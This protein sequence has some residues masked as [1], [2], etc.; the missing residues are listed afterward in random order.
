MTDL[1]FSF[2]PVDPLRDAEL[3][4]SWIT[5]PK[6]A[7]WMMQ[8]ARLEDIER[9][10]ME[11]AADEHQQALLGLRDGV[12]AF[13][14]ERYDPVHRELVGLYEPRPGDVGMHF[15]TPATD[16]PEHGFTK[17]VITAV[18][19]HLFEDPAV[20]RVVVEPDV[21]NKA[22]HALNAAVG[23]VAEREIQKPEKEALL[24]FCTREQF[25]KAV[26]A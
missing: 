10:Y 8:D 13:L 20:E 9:A 18:M 21:R 14:V 4:H 25:T 17:A 5:H 11:I 3:L 6:A 19:A 2:R 26:S 12:P 24:S 16:T 7:F 23:F 22:V 1:T 15:L